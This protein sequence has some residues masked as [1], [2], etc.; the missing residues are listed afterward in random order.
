MLNP[1]LNLHEP[2]PSYSDLDEERLAQRSGRT[3]RNPERPNR[4]AFQLGRL[5]LR[6]GE[7]LTQ[8]DPCMEHF[9][10]DHQMEFFKESA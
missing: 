7:K 8:E 10:H 9:H 1:F 3:V 6:L 5:F 4:M 2:M